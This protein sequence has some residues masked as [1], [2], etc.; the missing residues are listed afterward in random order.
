MTTADTI[1]YQ[2]CNLFEKKPK[3]IDGSFTMYSYYRF[4]SLIIHGI[5]Q[6]MI[7]EGCSEA[8]IKQVL[9][10]K[11]VRWGLDSDE[12]MFIEYGKQFARKHGFSEQYKDAK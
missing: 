12:D 4:S 5:A 8:Q 1:A 7:D 6:Q 11:S 10:S 2:A 3:E 9:A